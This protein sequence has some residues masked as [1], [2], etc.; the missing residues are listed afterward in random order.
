MGRTAAEQR[1]IAGF[2][3][4]MSYLYYLDGSVKKM[5]YPSG[6][7]LTYTPSAAARML[8]AVDSGNGINYATG[9]TYASTG[10]LAGLINGNSGGVAQRTKSCVCTNGHMTTVISP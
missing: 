1:S 2:T 9:A 7:T 4:N 3:K 6:A 10:A 8:S 5:T